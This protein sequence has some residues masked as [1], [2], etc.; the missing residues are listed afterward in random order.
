MD[1]SVAAIPQAPQRLDRE[2]RKP[3]SANGCGGVAA[4]IAAAG[5]GEVE[6]DEI[7]PDEIERLAELALG[8]QD[9]DRRYVTEEP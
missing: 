4:G 9:E 2:S 8:Y 1:T 6:D 5:E 7:D 3:A